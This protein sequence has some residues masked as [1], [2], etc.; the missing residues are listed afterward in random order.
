LCFCPHYHGKLFPIPGKNEKK[1]G[2]QPAG[3][4]HFWFIRLITI[5]QNIRLSNTSINPIGSSCPQC[6]FMNKKR[7][8]YQFSET[9]LLSWLLLAHLAHKHLSRKWTKVGGMCLSDQIVA[10]TVYF[11]TIYRVVTEV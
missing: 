8:V 3:G 4:V 11:K 7:Q 9:I 5:R 2:W 6:K 1:W 10:I